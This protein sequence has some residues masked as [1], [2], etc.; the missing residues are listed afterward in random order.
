M[1]ILQ[2]VVAA[3]SRFMTRDEQRFDPGDNEGVER[4]TVIVELSDEYLSQAMELEAAWVAGSGRWITPAED[5][6]DPSRLCLIAVDGPTSAASA[7]RPGSLVGYLAAR[8][9]SGELQILGMAV[10]PGFRRQGIGRALVNAALI[11]ARSSGV[12]RASLEVR[13]RNIPARRLYQSAGFVA[14]GR[15]RGYYEDTGEDAVLMWAHDL[16]SPEWYWRLRM[17]HG[18]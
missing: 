15:R 2:S 13:E 1:V 14:L 9:D 5:L 6:S 17:K 11:R 18:V 8:L 12:S 3:R 16:R 7:S 10:G 4:S